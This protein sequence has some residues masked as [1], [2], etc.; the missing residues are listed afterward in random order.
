[1]GF[2]RDKKAFLSK[3]MSWQEVEELERKVG[4]LSKQLAAAGVEF[5]D[6]DDGISIGYKGSFLDEAL[7]RV[8][9]GSAG[10]T[11]PKAVDPII[12]DLQQLFGPRRVSEKALKAVKE[13]EVSG[14]PTAPYVA[15]LI[16]GKVVKE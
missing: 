5:K 3:H 13:L 15:D 1:M 7:A 6:L 12:Q 14:H 4:L 8:P 9:S 11:K 2:S 16:A 10:K